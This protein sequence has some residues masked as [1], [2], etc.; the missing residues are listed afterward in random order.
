[1]KKKIIY[2]FLPLLVLVCIV[3]NS[4]KKES[5]TQLVESLLTN[6]N[7]QLASVIV[8]SY[9]GSSE[10][11]PDTMNTQCSLK[12]TFQFN[13]DHT[14]TYTNFACK[15]QSKTGKWSLSTDDL[16]LFSD[17]SCADTVRGTNGAR[18]TTDKPFTYAQLYNLG[19]YSLVI[20]TGDIST[21]ATSTTKRIIIEYGFVHPSNH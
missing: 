21:Y 20:K 2:I 5:Q 9:I 3:A 6:G 19:Q 1:M 12:Q 15:T 11:K 14:C 17:M 16:Y 18:D 13:S 7:W 4:C 10:L 8:H